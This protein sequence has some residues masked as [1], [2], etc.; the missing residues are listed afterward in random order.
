MTAIAHRA[1]NQTN[2]H[3]NGECVLLIDAESDEAARIFVELR[4]ATDEQL[5]VE[6]VTELSAGIERLRTGAV[7]AIVLDLTL[8]ESQGAETFDK[9]FHASPGVPILILCVAGAEEMARQVMLMASVVMKTIWSGMKPP[10]TGCPARC[11]R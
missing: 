6:W 9:L 7:A 2:N 4:S 8:L 11:A 1:A 3:A 10:A 5:H